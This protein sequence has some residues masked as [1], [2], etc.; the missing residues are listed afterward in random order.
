MTLH[1]KLTDLEQLVLAQ[2]LALSRMEDRLSTLEDQERSRL[3]YGPLPNSN[4]TLLE[5][6]RKTLAAQAKAVLE[7]KP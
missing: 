4:V 3:P 6:H 1:L 7:K 2:S 5:Q